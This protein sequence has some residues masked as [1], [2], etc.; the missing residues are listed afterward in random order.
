MLKLYNVI[1]LKL[2][3]LHIHLIF[4]NYKV[5]PMSNSNYFKNVVNA[6]N[7]ITRCNAKRIIR[8]NKSTN[9]QREF[10]TKYLEGDTSLKLLINKINLSLY[11][12]F[13][14]Y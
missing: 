1:W 9:K 13:T 5:T 4:V 7:S 6:S 2:L 8:F 10:A 11:K 12:Q 14:E 3:V